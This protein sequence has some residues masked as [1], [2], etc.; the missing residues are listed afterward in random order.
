MYKNNS[1][2]IEHNNKYSIWYNFSH[3]IN[4]SDI[5][6]T[7]I[8]AMDNHNIISIP[9]TIEQY[10]YTENE[11]KILSEILIDKTGEDDFAND[12]TDRINYYIY[13]Y[14]LL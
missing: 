2:R 11:S 7:L 10:N 3:P 5:I 6:S 13:Y 1:K 14:Y 4:V 8:I 12:I 9:P